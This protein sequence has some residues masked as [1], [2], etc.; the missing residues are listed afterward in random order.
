MF[1]CTRSRALRASVKKRSERP[2]LEPRQDQLN[3]HLL[4]ESY[5][6][7]MEDDAHASAAAETQDLVALAERG[8]YELEVGVRTCSATARPSATRG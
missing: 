5:I 2:V 7:C 6:E 4:T 8:A 3:R 1:S